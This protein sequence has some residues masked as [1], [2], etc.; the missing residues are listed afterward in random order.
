MIAEALGVPVEL[1]AGLREKSYGA[2]E[3]RLQSWLDERFV[4]SRLSAS[5]WTT[6]RGSTDVPLCVVG[7]VQ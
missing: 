2:A 3:R 4:A 5:A 7:D 6:T 1:D